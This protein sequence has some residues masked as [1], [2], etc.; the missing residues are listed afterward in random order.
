MRTI[1]QYLHW[2]KLCQQLDPDCTYLVHHNYRKDRR[3]REDLEEDGAAPLKLSEVERRLYV[4][5]PPGLLDL[6]NCVLYLAKEKDRLEKLLEESRFEVSEK[7]QKRNTKTVFDDVPALCT[8]YEHKKGIVSVQFFYGSERPILRAN[9]K[10][11][12]STAPLSF[13]KHVEEVQ[14]GEA[15]L[16]FT[17]CILLNHYGRRSFVPNQSGYEEEKSLEVGMRDNSLP[18][19]EAI[20]QNRI[21]AILQPKYASITLVNLP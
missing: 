3:T 7:I 16:S 13:Y 18:L 10:A 4:E 17:A 15:E 1:Q 20:V 8:R 6:D 5:G 19:L 2:M 11:R 21:P 12:E 14:S 9:I